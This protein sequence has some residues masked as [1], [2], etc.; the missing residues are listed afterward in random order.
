MDTIE[1]IIRE[2]ASQI[3]DKGNSDCKL[4]WGSGERA[5]HDGLKEVW[6]ECDCILELKK[7]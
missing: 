7:R 3:G 2:E 1:D 4:C 6:V 5:D